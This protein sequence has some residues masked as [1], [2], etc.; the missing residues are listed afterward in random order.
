M[1]ALGRALRQ[2][3]TEQIFEN[4]LGFGITVDF[5]TRTYNITAAAVGS[6]KLNTEPEVMMRSGRLRA[7]TE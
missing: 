7:R 5:M 2:T 4:V 1:C 3:M 6:S